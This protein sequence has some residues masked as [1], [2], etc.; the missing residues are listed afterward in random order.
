MFASIGEIKSAGFRK[1]ISDVPD[2]AGSWIEKK[3]SGSFTKSRPGQ[4]LASNGQFLYP[5]RGP[6]S[7]IHTL[8]QLLS[9]LQCHLFQTNLFHNRV[10][11]L[12]KIGFLSK[13]NEFGQEVAHLWFKPL[14][15]KMHL[16]PGLLLLCTKYCVF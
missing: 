6:G 3:K 5:A 2:P 8:K 16:W 15:I 13:F 7:E 1:L 9:T 4:M 11:Y 12:I 10:F 14:F